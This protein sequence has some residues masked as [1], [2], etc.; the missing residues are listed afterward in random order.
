[1]KTAVTNSWYNCGTDQYCLIGLI[2]TDC[3]LGYSL[4]SGQCINQNSCRKYAYYLPGNVSTQWTASKCYCLR[5][6]YMSNYVSCDT[7]CHISCLTCN[8]TASNQCTACEQG[9]TLSSGSCTASQTIISDS[10]V[11][12]TS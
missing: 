1:M 9:F 8:G 6:F 7:L 3:L 10:Y 2:C 4:V 5:G 12:T 11:A